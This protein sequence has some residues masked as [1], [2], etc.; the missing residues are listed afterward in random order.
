MFAA[1]C[2]ED[3]VE[4]ARASLD[5]REERA[6]RGV[7]EAAVECRAGLQCRRRFRI[8]AQGTPMGRFVLDAEQEDL[9][10]DSPPGQHIQAAFELRAEDGWLRAAAQVVLAELDRC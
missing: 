10:R 1:D 8:V 7:A 9:H 5:P 3:G 6:R 2:G 4:L